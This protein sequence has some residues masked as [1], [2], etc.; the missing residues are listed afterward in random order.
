MHKIH[1]AIRLRDDS[2]SILVYEIRN[3]AADRKRTASRVRPKF[4]EE[5]FGRMRPLRDALDR[6]DQDDMPMTSEAR[7]KPCFFVLQAG[8]DVDQAV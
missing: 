1:A 4:R 8:S 2:F 3:A 7:R 6:Q 5:G